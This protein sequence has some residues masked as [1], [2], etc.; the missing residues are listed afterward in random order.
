[1]PLAVLVVNRHAALQELAEFR[2]AERFGDSRGV[3]RFGLI[4]QE[5]PVAIGACDQRL[6]RLGSEGEGA[7]QLLGLFE[8]PG[9]G[10]G[11]ESVQDQ[12]LRAAQKR[13]V[14]FEAGVLGGRADQCHHPAF[15]EGQ[16]AILLRAV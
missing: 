7:F 15:D 10:R 9:E 8:Q 3:E 5:A 2:R 13:G 16:K 4:E 6:A 1:M 14:E 12:H 11:I